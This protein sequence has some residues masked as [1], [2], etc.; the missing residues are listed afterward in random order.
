ML[1]SI[2][3]S[4]EFSALLITLSCC[5][6][7]CDSR[8]GKAIKNRWHTLMNGKRN[9]DYIRGLTID[10]KFFGT[11]KSGQDSCINIQVAVDCPIR[12]KPER[13]FTEDGRNAALKKKGSDSMYSERY[14]SVNVSE[15][16]KRPCH[17]VQW[18]RRS[19]VLQKILKHPCKKRNR[20]IVLKLH[21]TV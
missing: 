11:I 7:L 18:F 14:V 17:Q 16:K 20:Q 8:T 9:S 3:S 6:W 13:G 15:R 19:L 21:L 2:L 12:P 4:K 1:L 5:Q 10:N